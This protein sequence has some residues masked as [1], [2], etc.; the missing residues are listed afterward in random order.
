MSNT[1]KSTFIARSYHDIS[2]KIDLNLYFVSAVHV[3][4][5]K[6]PYIDCQQIKA[7]T[8]WEIAANP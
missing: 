4:S 2:R 6:T 8:K 3:V 1:N 5:S 7:D